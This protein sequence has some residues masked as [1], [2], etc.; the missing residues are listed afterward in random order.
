MDRAMIEQ[1][2]NLLRPLRARI[3]QLMLG[4]ASP[5]RVV[6]DDIGWRCL[7]LMAEDLSAIEAFWATLLPE[8]FASVV[9]LMMLMQGDLFLR[10]SFLVNYVLNEVDPTRH[11]LLR[12]AARC[13]RHSGSYELSYVMAELYYLTEHPFRY[14]HR[15]LTSSGPGLTPRLVEAGALP[16]VGIDRPAKKLLGWLTPQDEMDKSLRVMA[17][18][19]PAGCGKTILA[20]ELH[21]RLKRQTRGEAYN[22]KCN[23]VAQ[24]SRG[25][26]RNKLLLQDILSQLTDQAAQALSSDPSRPNEML[27][28]RGGHITMD[29]L[30]NSISEHLRDKRYLIIIDDIWEASD[31]E[32]IEGAFPKNHRDSRILITT[33]V[34][35]TARVC[36]YHS[37][38][39]LVHEMKPLN[40]TDSK[41]LLLA[42]AF[43]P[44]G[45]CLPDNLKPRCDGILRRC[46]G[47]P[48]FITGMADWLKI[49]L[50]QQ[51]WHQQEGEVEEHQRLEVY[52]PQLLPRFEQVLSSA[53]SD[54]PTELRS[55]SLY[56]SMFPYGYKFDKDYLIWKWRREGLIHWRETKSDAETFFS[57]L[58]DR[59]VI[60]CVPANCKHSRDEAE[61]FQWHV[62]PFMQQF[63]ASKSAYTGFAF[64]S[65]TLS[66][67]AASATDLGNETRRMAPHR[68][69]LHHP[70]PQLPSLLEKI[71]LS[72]TRSLAV[73]GAVS[74]IPMEKFVNL[75]VLDLEGWEN[76]K[77]E[78][79]RQVCRSKMFLLK[80]LSVRSTRVSKLPQEVKG[81]R[82]L[83]TLDISYTQI[84]ELP[85][86]VFELRGLWHL[87]LRG[88]RITQLPRQIEGLRDNLA[89]LL[90][91]GEGIVN[92]VETAAR[93]TRDVLHLSWLQ[94][95][96]TVDLTEHPAS[97]VRALGG[98]DQLKV[99]AITWSFAQST[100]RDCRE[101]LLSSIAKWQSLESLTIH[102]GLGCS[103]QFLSS[104][105]DPPP[106]LQKF[107][108]TAGRFAS[109]PRWINV[110]LH[111]CFLQITICKQGME[112]LY[113]L[114]GL[115]KLQCLIL[116]LD[117]IPREAISIQAVGFRELL[118]FS[119]DCPL[120]WLT[121]R[122]GAM[123]KLTYLQ[124]KL[125]AFPESKTSVPSS[126]GNLI[127]LTEVVLCY[128]QWEILSPNISI[129]VGAV[130]EA[131]TEHPNQ[132]DLFINGIQEYEVQEVNEVTENATGT[133]SGTTNAGA[134][135]DAQAVKQLMKKLLTGVMQDE[136]TVI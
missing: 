98:L 24:A 100:D 22:F 116:G 117:F 69:A 37:F 41:R 112:D 4:P 101:A 34:R 16:L 105:S 113:I 1:V 31:W 12:R 83:A 70:D 90:F 59:N 96:A 126:I 29:Q 49:Q 72:Q 30:I 73:S 60:T 65:T 35:G 46:Q 63:L 48:L 99:V 39:E 2:P 9:D 104:L 27:P 93:V 43:G 20:M 110:L 74:G 131:V 13:F 25:T 102:C 81:L 15:L 118:R 61:A 71:D 127:S 67:A 121:F 111:L 78:D 124:L 94:S 123:R 130:R 129:I 44:G 21:D 28:K 133:S 115:P 134:S 5:H 84:S 33:R 86:E 42:K 8:H 107:K 54:L 3:S 97:F 108:V 38:D 76:L 26:D 87:D 80:Y 77:D 23:V 50:Q 57:Q 17:I 55:L 120:P 119:I 91:G 10:L 66:S 53:F 95:L 40:H 103:M 136:I 62:N 79:L 122:A 19:G 47:I 82:I 75:V 114:G 132:I 89:D 32:E 128:N 88:T 135:D 51:R 109:A 36:C 7:A 45:G 64:T 14:R 106:K 18:I 52:C 92:S 56:M 68:L 125:C 58:V 6:T 11:T 85:L